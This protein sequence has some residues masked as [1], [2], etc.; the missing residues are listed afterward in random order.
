MT[1]RS[2]ALFIALGTVACADDQ[3][4]DASFANTVDTFTIG[5]LEGTPIHIPS[6]YS[7][8][9]DRA[10]R[11][12]VTG[13]FDFVYVLGDDGAHYLVPLDALGLGGRTSNPGLLT[14]TSTFDALTNPPSE[15]YLTDDSVSVAVGDVIVAR[16]RIVCG[17]GVP[18]YARIEILSFDDLARTI[19]FRS[20][21]NINCGYRSLVTG[22]PTD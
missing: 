14:S 16:S 22:I 17:L 2:I 1:F 6:A 15:G 12:D 11:T 9:D 7:V 5:D 21:A 10:I 3:L 13:A 20:L 18:Q 4:A 8:P 19:R